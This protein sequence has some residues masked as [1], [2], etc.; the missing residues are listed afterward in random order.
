MTRLT[1]I[2]GPTAVGK[3]TVVKE[4]VSNHPEIR[5]SVS[6]TTRPPRPGEV[7]GIHYLFVD[8]RTFDE[9]L[10]NNELL[11]HAVVHQQYRYGTPRGP[12]EE[13][14]ANNQQMIL[15]IDVQ[16]ARQIRQT[17]PNANL[18]F[19]APPSIDELLRR[20]AERGT[21]TP[22]QIAIRLQTAMDEM[23][24]VGEFDHV[25]INNEVAQAAREVLELMQA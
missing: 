10:A 18:I 20:L 19:L 8:D 2:A 21:E 9:M 7:N 3:G 11:E 14:L 1:V 4:I 16:G 15:E 23:A 13:A 24:S 22:D 5:L 6:A 17:M 12:V 25:V